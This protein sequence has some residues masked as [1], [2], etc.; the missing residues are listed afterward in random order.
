MT[1]L[2]TLK[3]NMKSNKNSREK[4][5]GLGIDTARINTLSDSDFEENFSSNSVYQLIRS[6]KNYLLKYSNDP[7]N[8]A[9]D[10]IVALYKCEFR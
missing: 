3:I 10:K 8:E 2:S 5:I 4:Y 6:V 7:A 1:L 9:F